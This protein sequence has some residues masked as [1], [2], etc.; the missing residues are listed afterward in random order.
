MKGKAILIVDDEKNIRFTLTRALETLGF[1]IYT[2]EN[3]EEAVGKLGMESLGLVLLDLR[4]PRTDGLEVLRR[5]RLSRPDVRVIVITAHG[6]V[7]AS[8]EAMKLGAVDFISKPFLP[9]QVRELVLRVLDR[10]QIEERQQLDYFLAVELAKRCIHEGRLEAAVETLRKAASLDPS[11]PEAFNLLGALMEIRRDFQEAGRYYRA[12]I[13]LD[14][15]Y[16][17][18][19]KNLERV[20]SWR[21]SGK[22][23]I[24]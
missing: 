23:D 21:K 9:R 17:P 10:G 13:S 16:E 22:V 11:R 8:V 7:E 14:P 15:T 5:I 12:A 3:G 2:A 1:P 19:G 24:D 20:T 4:M 18:A 6:T